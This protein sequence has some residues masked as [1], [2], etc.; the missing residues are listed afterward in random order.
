MN[1]AKVEKEKS[2]KNSDLNETLFT[3]DKYKDRKRLNILLILNDI[4]KSQIARELGI[5]PQAVC[6]VLNRR[7]NS[8]RVFE[9]MENLPV[10]IT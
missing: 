7:K 3:G 2:F 1:E 6:N 4:D 5:S 10:Q 9:Y 8:R